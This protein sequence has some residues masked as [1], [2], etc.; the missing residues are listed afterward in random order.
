MVGKFFFNVLYA[1]HK[2]TLFCWVFFR[3]RCLCILFSS[4]CL[5]LRCDNYCILRLHTCLIF[6]PIL[7]NNFPENAIFTVRIGFFLLPPLGPF[8]L[9]GGFAMVPSGQMISSGSRLNWVPFLMSSSAS[10]ADKIFIVRICCQSGNFFPL[11]SFSS[12]VSSAMRS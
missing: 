5:L 7:I 9:S 10:K 2:C 12:S 4:C 8:S 1:K 3:Q 6:G 11:R